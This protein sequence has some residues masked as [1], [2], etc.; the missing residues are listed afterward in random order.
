MLCSTKEQLRQLCYAKGLS[1]SAAPAVGRGPGAP[2]R[3][4]HAAT[5]V[6][7]ATPNVM[8]N[9]GCRSAFTPSSSASPATA[10]GL[11]DADA[12]GVAELD[13]VADAAADGDVLGD[14]VATG[15]CVAVSDGSGLDGAG[16]QVDVLAGDGDGAVDA[17]TDPLAA[18]EHDAVETAVIDSDVEGVGLP[19]RVAAADGSASGIAL[20]DGAAEVAEPTPVDGG[21]AAAEAR[22]TC[23]IVCISPG[24][25]ALIASCDM[26]YPP[27][28]VNTV[29][30]TP[31]LPSCVYRA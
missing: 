17:D 5:A 10:A 11:R 13:A 7:M 3:A 22:R 24:S 29:L 2:R 14:V 19:L 21:G 16:V 9:P 25:A 18:A 20:P 26:W 15:E 12:G 4:N 6:A 23:A 30:L 28:S 27:P 1:V 8:A 31:A